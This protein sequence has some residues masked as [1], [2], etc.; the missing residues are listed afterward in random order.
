MT[1]LA[2]LQA[3]FSAAIFAPAT[4]QDEIS[5]H[6]IGSLGLDA[7]QSLA[8][9][10][11]SIL[12]SFSRV[13]A[14]TYPVIEKLLGEDFFNALAKEYAQTMPSL[15]PDL[16]EFG[17]HFDRFLSEFSATKELVYLPDVAQL[18]WLWEEV[19]YA[20]DDPKANF[21]AMAELN[22]AAL[23]KLRFNLSASARLLQSNYPL[24][25]IWQ[26]NQACD[27]TEEI[28]LESG[29]ETLLLLR[30]GDECRMDR[31]NAED[32]HLLNGIHDGHSFAELIEMAGGAEILN[33]KLPIYVQR[34]W[35]VGLNLD[36]C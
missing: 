16:G 33:G 20:D 24:L 26:A 9:Y 1:S 12:E 10:R 29:G 31:L 27:N 4:A 5:Q 19:F 35:I 17:R 15:Q 11:H 6:I 23:Q 28:D 22:D 30:Q 32:W 36:H 25:D 34:G 14:G 2:K 7:E 3:N 21:F 13:L 18:E 8:I